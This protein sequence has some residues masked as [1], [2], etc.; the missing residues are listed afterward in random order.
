M[1]HPD[2]L[3]TWIKQRQ[4]ELWDEAAHAAQVRQL[5]TAARRRRHVHPVDTGDGVP[6]SDHWATGLPIASASR[7]RDKQVA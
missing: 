5:K 4:R 6:A 1:I 3:L 7:A 2:I